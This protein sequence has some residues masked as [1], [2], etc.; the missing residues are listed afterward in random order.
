MSTFQTTRK[1]TAD[2]QMIFGLGRSAEYRD[3]LE[4]L[5]KRASS[6]IRSIRE[7]EG[8]PEAPDDGEMQAYIQGVHDMIPD[9]LESISKK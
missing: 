8:T 1:M 4:K 6:L 5:Q 2:E 3:F 7:Q 9:W